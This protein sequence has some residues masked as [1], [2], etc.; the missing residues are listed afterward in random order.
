M[1]D[2]PQLTPPDG[3]RPG[4]IGII[5][6]GRVILGDIATTIVDLSQRQYVRVEEAAGG[7]WL[8][9]VAAEQDSHALARYEKALLDALPTDPVLLTDVDVSVPDVA[10]KALIHDSVTRGW[11]RHLHH[12]ERTPAAEELAVHLRTFQRQMR[13]LRTDQGPEALTGALLPYA[14]HFGLIDHD[15]TPLGRFGSTWVQS[16]ADLPDWHHVAPK[17]A[18]D[19]DFSITLNSARDL[20][21]AAGMAWAAGMF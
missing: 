17:R 18:T 20:G 8:I 1:A 7:G 9:S 6:L 3:I 14:L 2:S 10:R 5:L 4:E 19:D 11:L 13:A 12:D 15:M 16:F 21:N